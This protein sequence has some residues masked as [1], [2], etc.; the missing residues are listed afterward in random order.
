MVQLLK[1]LILIVFV[2]VLISLGTA[3]YSLLRD[4]GKPRRM[5]NSLTVR[6]VL[7][8]VLFCLLIFAWFAGVIQP[9]DPFF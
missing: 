3:T 9:R 8:I 2:A 6:I 4:G 7:S 5:L 1:L